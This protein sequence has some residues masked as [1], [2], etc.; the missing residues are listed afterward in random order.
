V[1]DSKFGDRAAIPNTSEYSSEEAAEITA[2][3]HSSGFFLALYLVVA[4]VFLI[5]SY[6]ISGDPVA[7]ARLLSHTPTIG[8]YFES[9]VL[10][11]MLVSVH[12]VQSA[13]RALKGGN[14]ALVI[15]GTARNVGR[16]P[17]HLVQIEADLL[18]S[19]GDS[20]RALAH[21]SVYAGNDLSAEMLGQMTPREIEFSQS[22]SPQ[23]SFAIPPAAGVPFVMVFIN[24]PEPVSALRLSVAKAVAAASPPSGAATAER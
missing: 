3:P 2:R 15:T 9:P 22:L 11:A 8:E 10:P 5:A 7:S 6:M 17:L 24:P 16:S 20:E 19:A 14:R 18:G 13:Y 21:Q 1:I 23:K 4:I 12:D